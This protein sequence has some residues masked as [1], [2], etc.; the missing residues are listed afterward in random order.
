MDQMFYPTANLIITIK[1]GHFPCWPINHSWY[2]KLDSTWCV[3]KKTQKPR[4]TSNAKGTTNS[5][6]YL[7]SSFFIN[8]Q[9]NR[10]IAEKQ[11]KWAK[12]YLNSYSIRGKSQKPLFLIIWSIFS[13]NKQR[14]KEKKQITKRTQMKIWEKEKSL[15]VK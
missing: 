11:T 15:M 3:K 8:H 7:F 4:W 9:P 2:S 6:F 12:M 13:A 1:H 10:A 5:I 14:H